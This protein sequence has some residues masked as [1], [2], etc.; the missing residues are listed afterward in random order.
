MNSLF[1]LAFRQKADWEWQ[2][3]KTALQVEVPGIIWPTTYPK[4]RVLK[5]ANPAR[6]QWAEDF[7]ALVEKEANA[8]S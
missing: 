5:M 2:L 4:E 6:V 8:D 3:V 1:I 7:R